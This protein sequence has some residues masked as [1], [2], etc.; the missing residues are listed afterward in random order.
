MTLLYLRHNTNHALVGEMFG[1]S[2]DTSEN[3]F[4]EVIEVLK[5]EFPA[6]KWEAEKKFRQ[7]P[8]WKPSEVEYLIVDGF[9]TPI[10]RPSL[11]ERQRLQEM[12]PTNP[13]ARTGLTQIYCAVNFGFQPNRP[14]A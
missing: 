5:A 13:P 8:K 10:S 2:T 3:A 11:N 4:Y 14:L 7:E 9:E 6:S 1:V 12:M